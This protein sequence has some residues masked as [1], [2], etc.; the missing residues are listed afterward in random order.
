MV[1]STATVL[2]SGVAM[3][4]LPSATTNRLLAALPE[5]VLARWMPML[6][7]V[8]LPLGKVLYQPGDTVTWVYFPTSAI[9]SLLYVTREGESTEVALIGNDGIVGVSFFMSGKAMLDQAVV[10]NAGHAFRIRTCVLM[11]DFEQIGPVKNML[12]RYTQALMS[13]MEQ[14]AVCNRLHRLD[15]QLCRWLLMSMDLT[16]G[17]EVLMTQELLAHLL[18]V[19]RESVTAAAV[20]LRDAGLIRYARGHIQVLD[21]AGLEHRA[22][23]CYEVVRQEYDRLLGP[24]AGS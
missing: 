14:T 10:Q 2:I 1:A 19:R 20:G 13:Q 4:A 21:R 16:P 18:G 22:C 5:A 8:S 9:V 23:E 24:P 6:E 11:A 15:Q 12:V 17:N 7:P 3:T